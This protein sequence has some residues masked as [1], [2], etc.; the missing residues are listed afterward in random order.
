MKLSIIIVNWN[1][2]KYLRQALR[3][4]FATTKDLL[5]SSFEV[6]V[7]D[8]ASSDGGLDILEKEFPQVHLV[9]NKINLGFGGGNNEG[10]KKAKGDY[11][12]LLNPDVI[13]LDQAIQKLIQSTEHYPKAGVIIPKLVLAD[14]KTVQP[15]L[16][17]FRPTLKRM[18]L[19][20]PFKWFKRL[21]L[22]FNFFKQLAQKISLDF[23]DFNRMREV[24]WGTAAVMLVKRSLFEKLQ[25]FDEKMFMYFEDVDLCLRA[26]A[27]GSKIIYD[28]K[29]VIVHWGGASV[30]IAKDRRKIYYQ[31]QGYFWAKHYSPF[32][33]FLLKITRFPYRVV[34]SIFAK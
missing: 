22:R 5:K 1:T 32:S 13:I 21:I 16:I 30:K 10:A 11:L 31:S 9:K 4:V 2:Q 6:I 27:Q 33:V 26:K 25:G 29:P 8:N 14:K 17:N 15:G 18:I 20:K 12:L 34:K 3:S 7:V 24:D 19:E 23:W 28:P